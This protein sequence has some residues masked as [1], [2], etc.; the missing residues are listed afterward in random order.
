MTGD[1]SKQEWVKI[2]ICVIIPFIVGIVLAF[3]LTRILFGSSSYYLIEDNSHKGLFFIFLPVVAYHYFVMM[4]MKWYQSQYRDSFPDFFDNEHG[5]SLA[6]RT[7]LTMFLGT[8]IAFS[9]SLLGLTKWIDI[10]V[11]VL[12]VFLAFY[13]MHFKNKD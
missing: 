11:A 5:P 9:Y 1:I 3:F 4:P 10:P 13:N 2:W 7:F 8:F 12:V 6:I